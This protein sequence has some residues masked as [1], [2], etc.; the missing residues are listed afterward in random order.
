LTRARRYDLTGQAAIV[1]GAGS[2]GG[3]GFAAARQLAELGASVLLAATSERISQRSDELTAAGAEVEV[4][5]GDLSEPATAAS[6]VERAMAC[7]GSLEILVNNAGMT[8]QTAPSEPAGIESLSDAEWKVGIERNLATAFF[9]SRAAIGPMLRSG[10]GRIVNVAS[11][12]GP[13]AAYPGDVA[14]HAA[15]AGMVGLTRSIAIEVADRGITVNAVAPGWIATESATEDEIAL[16]EATPIG[17]PGTAEEV[18]TAIVGLALPGNSYVTGQMIV[19][20]G[21][22]TIAEQRGS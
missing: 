17:R 13:V 19:V 8:S 20:D 14:Y 12:S 1:T 2:K 16:G 15:K 7:F 11:V 5:V 18:A 4:F 6:L 22:N 21:G 3:I 9:V 10:Y